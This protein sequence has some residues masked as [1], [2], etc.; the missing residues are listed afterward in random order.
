MRVL[1]DFVW[2]SVPAGEE[3]PVTLSIDEESLRLWRPDGGWRVESEAF[4]VSLGGPPET[5]PRAPRG[6]ALIKPAR[7]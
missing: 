6:H 7:G 4:D 3:R 2:V 5:S 1:V